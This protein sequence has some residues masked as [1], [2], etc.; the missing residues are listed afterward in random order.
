MLHAGSFKSMRVAYHRY[1]ED[2]VADYEAIAVFNALTFDRHAE[3]EAMTTFS[4]ALAEACEQFTAD[5]LGTPSLA[6]WARVQ[7]AIA[8]AGATFLKAIRDLDGVLER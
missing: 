4:R 6:S 8:D 3:E 1:A 5:P 2:A 7:A